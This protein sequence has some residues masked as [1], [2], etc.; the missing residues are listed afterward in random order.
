MHFSG[1]HA[2]FITQVDSQIGGAARRHWSDN[3]IRVVYLLDSKVVLDAVS[4][5]RHSEVDGN[6][7]G[8]NI[9][10][11]A[12]NNQS[13]EWTVFSQ[14]DKF[15]PNLLSRIIDGRFYLW[16]DNVMFQVSLKAYCRF[17]GAL[18]VFIRNQSSHVIYFLFM[19][20]DVS[21]IVDLTQR[22]ADIC[23]HL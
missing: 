15:T 6:W 5:V 14:I 2:S 13:L 8:V 3:S 11:W 20:L 19:L 9:I 17:L 16:R 12:A 10:C 1:R 18:E 4:C 21:E 7:L 22:V 23:L